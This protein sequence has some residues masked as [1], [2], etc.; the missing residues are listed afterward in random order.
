M[1]ALA[2]RRKHEMTELPQASMADVATRAGVSVSTVSRAL[3]G[4]SL[5]SPA[6]TARVR[7]AADELSFA[8]S[9]AASSLATGRLGRIALLVSG[10]L[11]SWFNGAILEAIYATLHD[12][13]HELS[14]FRIRSRQEREEFFATLPA[15][16]NADA[17]IV[18]S[19]GLTIAERSRLHDLSMPV[20]Y[21]N[22][23]VQG[24]ASVSIDD[25]GGVRAGFRQLRNL[26]H[27]RIAFAG[28]ENQLGF[29]YSA[30]ER[31]E[32]Y[33]AEQTAAGVSTEDQLVITTPSVRGGDGV[34]ASLLT[35]KEPPTALQV[36]SDEL[37]MSVLAAM[38]RVGLRAPEDLSVL[39]FDDHAM[40]ALFGLSTIAQPV[41]HLGRQAATMALTLAAGATLAEEVVVVATQLVLRQT[42]GRA[43]QT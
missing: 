13:D 31:V 21:L 35:T 20:V 11:G 9:R 43:S 6:T 28:S 38:S 10:S 39:G 34:V 26:G 8:I 3:R 5:V 41:E 15:R 30:A 24:S 17:L 25:A 36:D 29:T 14:I 1:T 37:A 32:G 18:A 4:S 2:L 12:A 16:R 42:T 23:R 7:E 40:A 22:Q 19:F 27:R 33:R